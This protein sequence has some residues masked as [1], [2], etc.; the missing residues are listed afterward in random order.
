[1]LSY[2]INVVRMLMQGSELVC[3]YGGAHMYCMYMFMCKCA[4]VCVCGSVS[5]IKKQS[6]RQSPTV[7]ETGPDV[8]AKGG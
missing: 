1:M 3:V 5:G 6:H 4:C 2:R 8:G 7:N